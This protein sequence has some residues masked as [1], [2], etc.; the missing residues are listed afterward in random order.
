M[1]ARASTLVLSRARAMLD[2]RLLN[3]AGHLHS[4]TS[5]TLAPTLCLFG[6]EEEDGERRQCETDRMWT[7]VHGLGLG[8]DASQISHA[9]AAV[10]LGVA[11][12]KLAPVSSGG[13]A[14]A[15]SLAR[16]GGE[17]THDHDFFRRR[18]AF[19]Q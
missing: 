11:V 15:I 12:Q 14:Y 18:P 2:K 5:G 9:A 13:H 19:T 10:F 8:V 1:W 6:F 16:Y 7:S 4:R 17:V 3:P